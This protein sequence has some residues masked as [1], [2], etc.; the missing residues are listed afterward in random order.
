MTLKAWTNLSD[1]IT[2][3]PAKDNK[4]TLLARAGRQV[5]FLLILHLICFPFFSEG[6]HYASICLAPCQLDRSTR[7][8]IPSYYLAGPGSVFDIFPRPGGHKEGCAKSAR[9]CSL[10]LTHSK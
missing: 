3:V 1:L 7:I 2:Q 4:F 6:F 9:A 5:S 10:S 8:V